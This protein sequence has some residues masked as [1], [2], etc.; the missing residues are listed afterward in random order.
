[1]KRSRDVAEPLII[2]P[3]LTEAQ[4]RRFDLVKF[5]TWCDSLWIDSKEFGHVRLKWFA[6]Q[7]YAIEQ[8][9]KG[10]EQDIHE[11]VILKA[12]QLGIS[13]VTLALDIYWMFKH[14][15]LQ[16]AI[17]TDTDENRE[18]FRS[19]IGQYIASL[20]RS[21]RPKIKVHNRA[22]L[23][24]EPPCSSRL[25]YMVAGTKKKGDLGRAKAVNLLHAT[26]CSSWA[27]DAASYRS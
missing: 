16:A 14:Q 10:L 27:Q 4:R 9:A 18:V 7:R 15:G 19:L 3:V 13:T 12:R 5:E 6:P 21:S 2:R 17:V 20:P 1:M 25:M 26:E 23:I 24:C 22:Q 8:I 11:F